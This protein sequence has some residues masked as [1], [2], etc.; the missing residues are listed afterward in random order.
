MQAIKGVN[1]NNHQHIYHTCTTHVLPQCTYLISA[2]QPPFALV[3]HGW[4]DI[5]ALGRVATQGIAVVVDRCHQHN[6]ETG[7]VVEL[8]DLSAAGSE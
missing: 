8:R 5:V 1:L 2:D 6:V 7:R 3:L 4:G